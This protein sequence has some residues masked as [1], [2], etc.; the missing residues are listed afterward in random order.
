MYVNCFVPRNA[1]LL[2]YDG[3][4]LAQ[5]QE[6]L[7]D[8]VSCHGYGVWYPSGAALKRQYEFVLPP[9]DTHPDMTLYVIRM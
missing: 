1:T 3:E 4:W 7:T 8:D 9:V 5:F 2:G 6:N